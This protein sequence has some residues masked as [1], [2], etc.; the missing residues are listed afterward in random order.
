MAL[1][2]G[3]DIENKLKKADVKQPTIYD[4]IERMKPEIQRALPKHMDSD[5]IARIAITAL[6]TNAKL[7]N[8][9][10]QS[11]LAALMQSSQLGLEPNTPLGEAYLIP[12]KQDCQ[13]QI[14]Y[15]GLISLAQRTGEYQI[16]YAM[17]VYQND[18]FKYEYGLEP[19]LIHI[20]AEEPEGEP[21]G[22][23]AVYHLKNGG[24]AFRYWSRKKIEQ[25]AQKYSQ[26]FQKGWTSPWKTDF[27]SMAKKT[28]LKDLLKY[29]PKSIEFAR[30]F[31]MD[32]TVK[33]EIA[34]DMTEVP[35]IDIDYS[36]VSDMN[37]EEKLEETPDKQPDKRQTSTETDKPQSRLFGEKAPFED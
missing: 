27:D 31:S 33:Q 8:C 35:P 10:A 29:A 14:G 19:N 16:I 1:T 13:F 22:Y 25:H 24:K 30:I 9:N 6:R 37:E 23:Y 2:N 32:E 5:R 17:E 3:K 18:E 15:K 26:A 28:V 7:Q 36:G 34:A 12:Y 21:V 11:F 20:P 4:F